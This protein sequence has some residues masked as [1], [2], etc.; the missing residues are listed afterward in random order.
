MQI[1]N[2]NRLNVVLLAVILIVLTFFSYHKTFQ[3]GF[4]WDDDQLVINNAVLIQPDGFR[5]IWFDPGA[6]PQY[7]PLVFSLF[8]FTHAIFQQEAFGYHLVNVIL[9]LFNAILLW[10]VL[11]KLQIRAAFVCA[12][13]FA[14]H[15]VH[16]ESVAWISELKNVLSGFFYLISLYFYL[17][18]LEFD[19]NRLLSDR[20]MNYF[21]SFGF[22]ICAL[23]SKTVV[24]SL[25]VCLLLIIWWKNSKITIKDFLPVVP[26]F[27][28]GVS[29]ALITVGIEHRYIASG[30]W[31][32]QYSLLERVLIAGR[33]LWFY[34]FKL[35]WPVD[36]SFIYPRWK[37]DAASIFQYLFPIGIGVVLVCTFANIKLFGRGVLTALLIYMATIFPAI[38]LV[39]IY[40]MKFSFVSDHFQYLASM[41][42]I[43]L[44]VTGL[45]KLFKS[46]PLL[47]RV[48]F[49]CV[50]A[51][52]SILT[53]NQTLIY[54]NSETLFYDVLRKNP[55]CTMAHNNLGMIHVQRGELE[56]ARKHYEAALMIDPKD[57]IALANMGYYFNQVK[58][59]QKALEYY[60]KAIALH[61]EIPEAHYNIATLYMSRGELAKAI[62]AFKESIAASPYNAPAHFNLGGIYQSLKENDKA[63]EEY[64]TALH[65]SPKYYVL[66]NNIGSLFLEK[67]DWQLAL[68]YFDET[69][70][71]DPNNVEAWFKKGIS[72]D[73][74]GE[75]KLA[76]ESYQKALKISSEFK[77][78]D[79]IKKR[80]R[81]LQ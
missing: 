16:V 67:K 26:Y 51:V 61:P 3:N 39:N 58:D 70:K 47:G 77:G 42:L 38:G 44:Y 62:E 75:K 22:F 55:R 46:W 68:K 12:L 30:A 5:N 10:F 65:E 56:E 60:L 73:L 17:D 36:L 79:F 54:K 81:V 11:R 13:I 50:I 25:P 34:A 21:L 20:R 23:F 69:L 63:I 24:C 66:N 64:K 72:Y 29:I 49:F 6:T 4:I 48:I 74:A 18:F 78:S 8:R 19:R 57:Y 27:V 28:I 71:S 53:L 15:P 59:E 37:V 2:K 76:V 33:A 1:S 80:L 40:P 41:S 35:L 14:I 9:H 45:E 32:W 52:L 7:Y 31:Y 43:V